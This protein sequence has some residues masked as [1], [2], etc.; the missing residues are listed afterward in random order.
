MAKDSG[1]GRSKIG[2]RRGGG[3]PPGYEWNVELLLQVRGEARGFLNEDQYAYLSRQVR[4][5]ARHG[6]PT[7]SET[8]DIRPVGDLHELRQKGGILGKLNVRVFYLVSR[9][10]RTIVILGAFPKQ[11]DGP[12][13]PGDLWR[14]R[15]RARDY[16]ETTRPS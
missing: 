5:L 6:D 2:V 9:S 7:H 15:T 4:E 13:P 16:L 12:T 1:R 14:M 11:N 8:L 10:N 3:P